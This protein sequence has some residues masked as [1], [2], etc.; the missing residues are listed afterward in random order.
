MI[1]MQILNACFKTISC[2][3]MS[4]LAFVDNENFDWARPRSQFTKFGTT[5]PNLV[6][7]TIVNTRCQYQ[8]LLATI[9]SITNLQS[10]HMDTIIC[11]TDDYHRGVNN[12][13]CP[14]IHHLQLQHIYP[15]SIAPQSLLR[16]IMYSNPN[17]HL[18]TLK[19]IRTRPK[20]TEE[21][22]QTMIDFVSHNHTT[23]E[24]VEL[25]LVSQEMS[26]GQG[27]RFFSQESNG[28]MNE[29]IFRVSL[30]DIYI[31]LIQLILSYP[32]LNTNLETFYVPSMSYRHWAVESGETISPLL[33]RYLS[34]SHDSGHGIERIPLSYIAFHP[35]IGDY[36]PSIHTIS[37]KPSS[38]PR[39]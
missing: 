18:R 21:F 10:L 19:I 22:P 4:S 14:A 28:K 13:L 39:G 23:L 8:E 25:V 36:H 32:H 27:L 9:S 26:P 15:K 37:L 33:S 20:D 34:F 7:L 38:R 1:P 16:W 31:E 30:P 6:V 12:Y 24:H 17:P 29:R 5:F 11:L 3:S 2:M 35:Q